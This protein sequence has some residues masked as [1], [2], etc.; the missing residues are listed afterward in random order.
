MKINVAQIQKPQN[1]HGQTDERTDRRTDGY[2]IL[3]LR[4]FDPVAYRRMRCAQLQT[5]CV[6]HQEVT[7]TNLQI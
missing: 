7:K 2:I 6:D 4:G 5:V 3:S 1:S